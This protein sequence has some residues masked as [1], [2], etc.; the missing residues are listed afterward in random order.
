MPPTGYTSLEFRG[1][2]VV[3]NIVRELT[4]QGGRKD[5]S[6]ENGWKRPSLADMLKGKWSKDKTL[7][8]TQHLLI[9]GRK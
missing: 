1:E 6:F 5:S 7:G 2:L 4:A 9:K 3:R 8:E